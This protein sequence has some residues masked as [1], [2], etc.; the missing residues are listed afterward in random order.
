MQPVGQQVCA[1]PHAGPPLHSATH[2]PPTHDVPVAQRFPHWPQLALS[3]CGLVQPFAQQVSGGVHAGPPL[4]VLEQVP[5]EQLEPGGHANP[6]M[7][8]LLLSVCVLLHPDGQHDWP[9]A[10]I[11]PPLHEACEQTPLL[12]VAPAPQTM[13]H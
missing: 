2:A 5:C 3:V 4:Q 8:Q 6:H 13:P 1:A 11:G 7:P 10:H 9:D 12:Q